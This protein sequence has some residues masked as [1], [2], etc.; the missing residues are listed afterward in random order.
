MSMRRVPLNLIFD[1]P[2]RWSKYKVLRDL[3]QNF[4]DSVPREEWSTRFRHRMQ[5]SPS[6]GG[7]AV[8]ELGVDGVDF[9]YDW[10]IPIGASTKRDGNGEF[11]GYFG[12]GFKIAALCALRDFGWTLEVR[13]R[14]WHIRVVTD[15]LRVDGRALTALAYDV[16]QDLPRLSD[17]SLTIA[18]FSDSETLDI[19]L[20]SFFHP[21]NPL[22]D[23]PIWEGAGAAVYKRSLMPKPR[24][25]PR[26]D[27]G[28]GEGIV[29]AGFQALGSFPQPLAF[30]LHDYR[31]ND[32]E[33]QNFFQMDVIKVI[34]Q[35]ASRLPS[36]AAAEVLAALKRYWYD[37]PRKRYDFE[38]WYPIIRTL[39][40]RVADCPEQT[41]RWRAAHPHLLVADQIRRTDI[42]RYNRR[43]QAMDWWRRNGRGYRL[44][45]SAFRDLGYPDLEQQCQDDDGFTTTRLPN[46]A[47]Q[48]RIALLESLAK[49]LAPEL[50]NMIDLPACQII[51]N[52][53]AVWQGMANCMPIAEAPAGV[54][55]YWRGVRIRYRLPFI[56]LKA[57]LLEDDAFGVALSTYLHEIAHIFGGDRTAAFSDALSELLGVMCERASVLADFHRRWKQAESSGGELD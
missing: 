45:Q 36:A 33:R 30:C 29:F 4:F 8:L 27:R 49:A 9:S 22:I 54:R 47:E 2:V 3:I 17:T 21:N 12:E 51:D 56:A 39:V 5:H 46:A 7:E 13:S 28:E 25:Y 37:R 44:V 16:T 14:D 11:A 18:P 32:R 48:K 34:G 43:R 15:T 55:R 10:L 57:H 19:A 23:E 24:G 20:L 40:K 35:V 41:A 42:V 52:P 26:T 53:H 38:S 6:F 1:Y 31:S 50:V